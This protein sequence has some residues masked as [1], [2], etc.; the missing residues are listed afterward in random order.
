MSNHGV[1]KNPSISWHP[2]D[3]TLKPWIK[4]EAGRRGITDKAVLEEMA[5]EYRERIEFLAPLR[6]ARETGTANRE[7]STALNSA[8]QTTETGEQR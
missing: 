2:D 1:H 5:A 8:P 7:I 4:A 6:D 3:S